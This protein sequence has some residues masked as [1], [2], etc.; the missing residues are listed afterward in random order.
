MTWLEADEDP[1]AARLFWLNGL[2][3]IGKSTIA[4]TIAGIADEKG[5][6]GGSFFFA[7]GDEKLTD[8]T[9]VFPS[10]A[11]QLAQVD[12]AL[13][14]SIGQALESDAHYAYA[15]LQIQLQ[16]L[17]IEPLST[18]SSTERKR[19]VFILD[20][21]D[22]CRDEE[23]T[24]NIVALLLSHLRLIP[25]VRVLLTSRPEYHIQRAFGMPVDHIHSE[26]ILHN[27]EKTVVEEDIRLYLREKLK[28]ISA[29][30][31]S[32][33]AVQGREPNWPRQEDIETLVRMSGTLF[34]YAATALRFI[35]ARNPMRQMKILLGVHQA[36]GTKP[37]AQL[38]ELYIQILRH[39]LP[40]D[41]I[42]D[43]EVDIFQWVVG[44]LVLLRDPLSLS[45]LAD[46]TK[47]ASDDVNFTL[48]YL[49]SIIIVPPSPEQP[50][51]IYHPSFRDFLTIP[52]RCSE[53]RYAI[54]IHS[55]EKRLTLRCLDF[56]LS[57]HLRRNMLG[58]PPFGL[59]NE[60][61][62][63]LDL[64]LQST[65][66]Q[67]V[68]Y[69][70]LYWS[71]HLQGVD[72]DDVDV[73]SPLYEFASGYMLFWFEAMSLLK[74]IPR[75][76]AAM[77]DAH[78]W[79]KTSSHTQLKILM[80]DGYRFA[81]S[82]QAT[83]EEG[84]LQVYHSALPFT[85]RDTAL[86][87]TYALGETQSLRVLHG[88]LAQWSPCLASLSGEHGGIKAAAYSNDGSL[89]ALGYTSP[90]VTIRAAS[91]GVLLSTFEYPSSQELE[92]LSLV[93]LP[94]DNTL[95]RR[96]Y[97]SRN[98]HNLDWDDSDSNGFSI[99]GCNH[100]PVRAVAYTPD[101]SHLLS[102]SE[103]GIV[104]IWNVLDCLE[105]RSVS[106][107]DSGIGAL[108]ISP[109]GRS[110]CTGGADHLVKIFSMEADAPTFTLAGHTENIIWLAYTDNGATLFS[111]GSHERHSRF[112]DT[113]NGLLKRLSRG[114]VTQAAFSPDG[115]P[116][117]DGIFRI[118][119]ATD[120]SPIDDPMDHYDWAISVVFSQ[121]GKLLATGGNEND[122][123]V[124][125]W[126]ARAGTV[127][128][129]LGGHNWAIYALAFSKDGSML[130][131]GSGDATVLVWDV[132]SGNL[133]S[134]L[135]PHES[136]IMRVEFT[137]EDQNITSRTP[138]D[139]YTWNINLPDD[140]QENEEP[141]EVPV[142][143]GTQLT[144]QSEHNERDP[145]HMHGT[146]GD[147]LV[148][149]GGTGAH[150]VFMGKEGWNSARM[151]G[152]VQEEYRIT[153][154]AFHTDRVVIAC[155]DGSVLILDVSRVRTWL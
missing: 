75:A 10:L 62:I 74:Q 45:V 96:A 78:E 4:K 73:L 76:I 108:A 154:F 100:S 136:W 148:F 113:S 135:G 23:H 69:A 83:I 98:M 55:M 11:F 153:G 65:F 82:H 66:P 125:I 19:L 67:E 130:A 46:F 53:P 71:S 42:T 155:T 141:E 142:S 107:H 95:L 3:G 64:L 134:F 33:S 145:G 2:A 102:G 114:Y 9:L 52:G 110:Y 94:G 31:G 29:K 28:A 115:E 90:F 116:S 26:Y 44:T 86:F 58:L 143:V 104:R 60:Y 140:P 123:N 97:V 7:R 35:G 14:A 49:Q 117:T 8:P 101:G 54:E 20:A 39:G 51:Q 81:L 131:S 68:Q 16:K 124:K 72:P 27:I 122:K 5:I 99:H 118:W 30:L 6:L 147:Y 47:I 57:G 85:P 13:K 25:F 79:T 139:T 63:D 133:L 91:S 93:F 87:K 106:A 111:G 88:V 1:S 43:E 89:F 70:C 152:A 132:S 119:A 32:F 15:S 77:R 37:Y 103:D 56:L 121:D 128:R 126:D 12:P 84:A 138:E 146:S 137:E 22:E 40:L 105:L 120:T 50:P 92:V 21:L 48:T 36:T 17:I 129:T 61:I 151:V 112:W 80:Y 149:M 38:D 41:N 144:K 109:D 59:M 150:M 127:M 18:G 24:A 34:V